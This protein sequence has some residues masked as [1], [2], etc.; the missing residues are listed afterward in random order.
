MATRKASGQKTRKT[1]TVTTS[2]VSGISGVQARTKD[3]AV[4]TRVIDKVV[5]QAVKFVE[6]N[7]RAHISVF[8]KQYFARMALVDLEEVK[9]EALAKL[10]LHHLKSALKRKPK[11]PLVRVFSPNV[12][13]DGWHNGHTVI[14]IVGDDM[15]FLVDSVTAEINHRGY[16]IHLAVHPVVRVRRTKT[17]K[18]S[19]IIIPGVLGADPDT[20]E[21]SFIHLQIDEQ[22]EA[23]HAEIVDELLQV[24]DDVRL[25]VRDWRAMRNGLSQLVDELETL[26]GNISLDEISEARDFLRWLHDD[27]FTFLGFREYEFTGTGAKAKVVVGH[28]S[29]LGV[30]SD[31]SRVAF[32]EIHNLTKLPPEVRAFVNK[33]DLLMI[34]KADIFSRVHRSVAMDSIGIKRLDANG[35]VIGQRVFV[36]LF[37]ADTYHK[38]ARDIPVLRRKLQSTFDS[39]GLPLSSHDGKALLNILETFPRDELFQISSDQLL[40]TSLGIL[41]LTERQRVA[42]FLRRDTFERFISCLIYVPRDRYTTDLRHKFQSILEDTFGG[43]ITAH[44]AQL[45]DDP[46]A[47][48]HVVV[49]TEPGKIAKFDHRTLE[50]KL[51]DLARSWSDRLCGAL[52]EAHGEMEGI[53]LLD[54]YQDAFGRGYEDRFN[55]VETLNDINR[56]EKTYMYGRLGL[57][58]YEL[59]APEGPPLRFKIYHPRGPA[60]LSDVLPMLEDLGLRVMEE[61]PFQVQPKNA[62]YEIVLHDFGLEPRGPILGDLEEVRHRFHQ[63]FDHIWEGDMESDALNALILSAGLDWREVTVLRAYT[64]Y[65]RQTRIPF[66][67]DYMARTLNEN[68]DVTRAIVQLFKARFMLC[69]SPADQARAARKAA[70]LRGKVENLLEDVSNAD[71]DRIL[72]RYINLVDV[73]LRTNFHQMDENGQPKSWLSFKLSSRDIEDLPLPRPKVEIFV[74]APEV[75]GVHLRFGDVARGGLRWSDRRED[76]RTEVLGLVKAQQVKNAVIVPVGS[77]GGFVLKAPPPPTAG[78]DAFLAAGIACY[79]TFIRGLLDLTDNL[80]VKGRVL[81]PKN[82]VRHDGDDP[83]LVVAADKGTATFSDIANSVSEEFGFWLGDAFASGG[84]QGY[85]HKKM[86]ITARGGWESIKR[87][88]R[89]LGADTQSQDFTV[90]GVGDMSGDV[91]GNG[92]LLSPHICLVA[93]FNHMHIF[94][95]PT[96]NPA[97]SLQERQRLFDLPRSGWADYNTK[98]LSKGGVIF[99]RRAKSV[100]LTPQIKALL[101][102]TVDKM[103]PTDLIKLILKMKVDLLWFG[104]IGTYVKSGTESHSDAGDRANDAVRVDGRDIRARV[105]GEGANLGMTQRGRIEYALAGG[106]LNTDSIDNS[107]GVDCSDHEVNIKILLDVEVQQKNLTLQ[108]RNALLQRMTDEVGALVLWDNYEQTQAISIIQARGVRQADHQIRLMRLLEKAG[109]LNR[110]VE[111]LP[112]DEELT[113]RMVA[114]QALTR[115]EISVLMSYA[116]LWLFDEL[117]GSNLPD[118]VFLTQDLTRYFPTPLRK[119]YAAGIFKHRLRREIVATRITNS[120]INRVGGTFVTKIMEKTGMKPSEIARAF[121]IAREAYGVRDLWAQIESLDNKVAANTQITMLLDINTLIDRGTVWILRN[122]DTPINVEKTVARFQGGVMKLVQGMAG[123]LPQHYQ[124]DLTKRAKAYRAD[125]VPKDLAYAV[126]GLVNLVSSMDIVL[127]AERR[128]LEVCAVAKLYFAVGSRFRL[129][130]LRAACEALEGESHWQ[131][132]AVSALM[133]ELC[134]HQIHLTAQVLDVAGNK[135]DSIKAIA[136][137]SATYQDA[138]DRTEQLLTELWASD[139]NDISMVA[140]ASRALKSLT[141][142]PFCGSA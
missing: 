108:A 39:A 142:E 18:L 84:S 103:T 50:A 62:D 113:E 41:R 80:D 56:L 44:Y 26:T 52:V 57:D 88:F 34:T 109:R 89:E 22:P 31:C 60:A 76:F 125:G 105:L 30:L 135:T 134:V 78:R 42:L 68:S 93:A 83:Y 122:G 17:G 106:C 133:E 55:P 4:R 15:P 20:Y 120:M 129:G 49:K 140:V 54:S 71:Q 90:V 67:E 137:W 48:L 87:H 69:D 47:R 13:K 102:V 23:R 33:P 10:A 127:L 66:S 16:G 132:L 72:R 115:P 131:K 141:D 7:M 99:E 82:V 12:E 59:N 74:Y 95:D 45:G 121:I 46:M 58:L 98:L 2:L 81:P 37:T 6:K 64:K 21:E 38:S 53:R 123:V 11:T 119:K 112:S 9:P 73:T 1:K 97:K 19:E 32:K 35:R 40:E 65:L 139:I 5:R 27:N 128:K 8:V 79:K 77:K 24:L 100:A 116:K 61:I 104:G 36:G 118:D 94:L 130:R 126:A 110:A 14:E 96:P 86:G 107:A 138:I 85:D 43:T 29:G 124:V 51:A 136:L 63:A 117:L 70:R 75:E 111:Y 25:V 91:F 92:M 114:G 28:D 3:Q 101:G